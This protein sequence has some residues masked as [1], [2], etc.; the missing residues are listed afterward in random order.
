MSWVLPGGEAYGIQAAPAQDQ[1]CWKR[2]CKLV[3][4][5]MEGHNQTQG[6]RHRVPA[7]AVPEASVGQAMA[8]SSPAG[9]FLHT[10]S[11]VLCSGQISWG[12]IRL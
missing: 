10:T 11:P 12:S 2:K 1:T 6:N 9:V 4:G 5:V 8:A 3:D 7:D